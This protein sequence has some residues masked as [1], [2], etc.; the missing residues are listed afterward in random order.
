ME[1]R[2]VLKIVGG[3]GRLCE[4]I[5][6]HNFDITLLAPSIVGG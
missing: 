5:G 3:G 1:R 4:G 6:A 2:W